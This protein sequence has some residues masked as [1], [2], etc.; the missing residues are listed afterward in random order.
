MK[1]FLAVSSAVA[2]LLPAIALAANYNDVSLDTNVVLSIGGITVNVSSDSTTISSITVN[3]SNFTVNMAQNST[4]SVTAPNRNQLNA[5]AENSGGQTITCTGSASS[6]SIT[7][8]VTQTVT[9]TPSSTLCADT[10]TTSS[11]GGGGGGVSGLI[12]VSTAPT[13][14]TQNSTKNSSNSVVAALQAQLNALLAQMA[15]LKGGATIGGSFTQDLQLGVGN[16]SQVR[17]LQVYLNTH[18]YAVASSGP[19]SPG[20]ETMKFGGATKAALIKFQKAVGITPASGFFGPKTRAY[21]NAH[22]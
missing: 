11:G 14:A 16:S 4:I 13:I 21:L 5:S 6:V 9:F 19:G 7:S 17:T 3:D 1:K 15:M 20:N 8:S 12:T 2:L 22:P 18:G 10:T